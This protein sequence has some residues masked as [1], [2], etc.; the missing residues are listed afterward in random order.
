M[1]LLR[2]R[3]SIAGWVVGE[4]NRFILQVS[5]KLYH[6]KKFTNPQTLLNDYYY[7]LL[8]SLSFLLL[9]IHLSRCFQEILGNRS[10]PPLFWGIS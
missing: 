6:Y 7:D 4:K 10:T 9:D 2:D 5:W 8:T 3:P 1:K